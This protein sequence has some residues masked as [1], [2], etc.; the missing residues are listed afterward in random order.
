MNL[1]I[2]VGLKNNLQYTKFFY[3]TLRKLYPSI[4][5]V[6]VSYGSVDGT[7]SWLDALPDPNLK[8]Y[9]SNEKKSLADTYNKCYSLATNQYVAFLHN[10]MVIAEGFV[11]GIL[12]EISEDKILLYQVIEP[13]IFGKDLHKWKIIKD[14]GSNLETFDFNSFQGFASGL[15]KKRFASTEDLC[16]F[17]SIPRSA[18][19]DINGL[20][21]LFNPMFR[22]DDDLLLRLQLY[23]MTPYQSY[24]SKVYHFV[25][26]TSRFSDE[27][28]KLSVEIENMSNRNFHRKWGFGISSRIKEKRNYGLILSNANE[29]VLR[30]LEP[31]VSKIYST[32]SAAHYIKEEQRF[33]IIPLSDKFLDIKANKSEDVLIYFDSKKISRKNISK[34]ENLSDE[35]NKFLTSKRSRFKNFFFG[36]SVFKSLDLKIRIVR[37]NTYQ[38]QLIIRK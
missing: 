18:L 21:P 11:E 1:S 2:L 13:P 16:F 27:Y 15:E 9:Y 34:F 17:L 5:I 28:S 12:N 36:K 3:A 31:Y 4:E 10:D 19:L 8:Y 23:G 22:E 26:K 33:T 35:I 6:F 14:F 7:H 37:L 25:S 32:F 38:K 24:N 30:I 29:N 20:D